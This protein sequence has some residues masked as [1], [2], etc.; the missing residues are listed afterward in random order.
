MSDGYVFNKH[1]ILNILRN[2][3]I[4]VDPNKE[5]EA[6]LMPEKWG[7]RWPKRSATRRMQR[8]AERQGHRCCYCG[9]RTWSQHY[10][11]AGE[12]NNMATIEHIK[13]RD[14]GGTFR[15]SNIVMVCSECNGRRDQSNP[16]IFMYENAG[17][18][19]FELVPKDE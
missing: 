18:L 3:A 4:Y 10:D 17:L 19:D 16:V 11:E 12:W 14:H 13:C 7:G 2:G 8:L 15:D 9:V 5:D 1:V 6:C